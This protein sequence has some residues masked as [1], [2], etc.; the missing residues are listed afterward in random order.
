MRKKLDET[1]EMARKKADQWEKEV[2]ARMVHLKKQ[3]AS[4]GF[5]LPSVNP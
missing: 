1:R 5:A 4:P 3:A 2:K